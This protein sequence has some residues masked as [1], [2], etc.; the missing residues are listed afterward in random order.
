MFLLCSVCLAQ[1]VVKVSVLC[2]LDQLVVYVHETDKLREAV[3]EIQ[4]FFASEMKRLGYGAKTFEF[5][6]NIPIWVGAR[7]LSFYQDAD[8]VRWQYGRGLNDFPDY[9][10]KKSVDKGP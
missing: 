6:T 4:A 10:G 8:D 5:E 3:T 2:P 9:S 7:E 1:P